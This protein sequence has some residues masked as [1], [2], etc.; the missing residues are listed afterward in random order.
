MGT[1]STSKSSTAAHYVSMYRDDSG[2][3]VADVMRSVNEPGKSGWA[4][5]E[6]D[7][8]STRAPAR[9]ARQIPFVPSTLKRAGCVT[10]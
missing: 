7:V 4:R 5:T 10:Y 2:R 9:Q 3:P 8:W 6:G 1:Y